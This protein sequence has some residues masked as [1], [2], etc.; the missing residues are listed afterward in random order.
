MYCICEKTIFKWDIEAK[1]LILKYTKS[2]GYNLFAGL[3]ADDS[4]LY[5]N[6]NGADIYVWETEKGDDQPQTHFDIIKDV[7]WV[8]FELGPDNKTLI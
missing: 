2:G 7:D 5:V 8:R 6:G 3:S 4:K 1:T